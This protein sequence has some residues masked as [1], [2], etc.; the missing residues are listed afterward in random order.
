LIDEIR[1][2]RDQFASVRRKQAQIARFVP[3]NFQNFDLQQNLTA[4]LFSLVNEFPD[5]RE[6]FRRIANRNYAAV[7]I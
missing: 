3:V 2:Q 4:C 1:R 5:E 7:G 6:P